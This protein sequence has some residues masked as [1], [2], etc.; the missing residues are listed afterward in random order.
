MLQQTQVDRVIEPYGRFLRR[1]PTPLFLAE[2][3]LADVLTLWQG[4]GYNRRGANL[5]RAAEVVVER[6]NGIL[7]QD[8]QQLQA[9]PGVGPYTASAV[10]IFAFGQAHPLIETN[11]RALYL[12]L[13]C[14]DAEEVHDRQIMPLVAATMD[15]TR[16][17]EWFYA[18]MDLGAALKREIPNPGR[19]SAHHTRQ[20]PFRGSNR[21]QR[22]LLLRAVLASSGLT[23]NELLALTP[24]RE[25]EAMR[26]LSDLVREGLLRRQEERYLVY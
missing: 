2:A 10:A 25:D 5:K 15:E 3:Q 24:G 9:L 12:H 11:I 1:F 14:S 20:S 17:R 6:N 4:L 8:V 19:R 23:S 21:E 22:S 16:P 18:L 26:N 13:F 7:P